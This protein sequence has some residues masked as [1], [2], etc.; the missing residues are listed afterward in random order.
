VA[1][2]VWVHGVAEPHSRILEPNE[3]ILRGGGEIKRYDRYYSHRSVG[4]YKWIGCVVASST[5]AAVPRT[6]D[7]EHHHLPM[8]L[9]V[10]A[11]S[12]AKP[13]TTT[14]R[15]LFYEAKTLNTVSYR[16]SAKAGTTSP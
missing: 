16:V 10:T 5:C 13:R 6:S 12:G 2:A 11:S 1:T 8:R 4:R 14:M 3:G 9:K 15:P 7:K